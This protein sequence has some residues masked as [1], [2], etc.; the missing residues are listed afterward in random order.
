LLGSYEH[1]KEWHEEKYKDVYECL[2]DKHKGLTLHGF[3]KWQLGNDNS[4]ELLAD[5]ECEHTG[6]QL[7]ELMQLPGWGKWSGLETFS[8]LP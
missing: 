3:D 1:D 7:A 5:K 6:C 2:Q 4:C 8:L